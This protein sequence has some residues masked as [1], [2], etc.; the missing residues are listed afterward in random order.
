[1]IDYTFEEDVPIPKFYK[2]IIIPISMPMRELYYY[3]LFQ[4]QLQSTNEVEE[5]FCQHLLPCLKDPIMGICTIFQSLSL[6]LNNGL[7]EEISQEEE[8]PPNEVFQK[9][10]Q[11]I[12]VLFEEIHTVFESQEEELRCFNYI[13]FI[14]GGVVLLHTRDIE[15]VDR[16]SA[17]Q[18]RL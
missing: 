15:N 18:T 4:R 13:S 12:S 3:R 8:V 10:G 14:T 17:L 11:E 9:A 5:Q 1:M 2:M 6:Y 7:I 16:I